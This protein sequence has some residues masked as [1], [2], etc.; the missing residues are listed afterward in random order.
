MRVLLIDDHPLVFDALTLILRRLPDPVQCEFVTL[1]SDGVARSLRVPAPD[2]VLLDLGLPGYEGMTA[3]T[4]FLHACPDVRVAVV[5]A[6]VERAVIEAC[7]AAGAIGYLPKT[8]SAGQFRTAVHAMLLGETFDPGG[9]PAAAGPDSLK[10]LAEQFQLTARQMDVLRQLARG[11]SNGAIGDELGLAI[12]T[13]K[14]HVAA[15]L[16]KLGAS[17]RTEAVMIARRAGL[18]FE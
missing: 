16:E 2:L 6:N 13:V 11:K 7:L 1:L 10:A 9:K 14:V 18:P 3:L 17:N 5:S 8:F 12:N 15:I 4:Q